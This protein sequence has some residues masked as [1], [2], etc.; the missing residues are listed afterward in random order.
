MDAGK[1]RV[2]AEKLC[3]ISSNRFKTRGNPAR[4]IR[5]GLLNS[6]SGETIQADLI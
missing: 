6:I 5:A 1:D 3:I 4:C 2:I